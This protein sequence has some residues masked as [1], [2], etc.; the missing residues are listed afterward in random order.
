MRHPRFRSIPAKRE[1]L[2]IVVPVT[3]ALVF[4]LLCVNTRSAFEAT[5]VKLAVLTSAAGA[6]WLFHFLDYNVSIA[7]WAG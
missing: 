2:K 7:A 5:V 6:S 1:R 3:V 4:V